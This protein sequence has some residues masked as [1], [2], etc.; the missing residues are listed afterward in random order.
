M[1]R[2]PQTRCMLLVV[3]A[4]H[5]VAGA[6]WEKRGGEWHCTN[7]APILKWMV[8]MRPDAVSDYL[9]RKRWAYEWI[10]QP[11]RPDVPQ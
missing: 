4:P 1:R 2:R 6:V 3:T 5:F 8:G 10:T 7:A 11:I 9:T